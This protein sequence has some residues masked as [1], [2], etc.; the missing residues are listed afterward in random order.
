VPIGAC[1]PGYVITRKCLHA[2]KS[3]WEVVDHSS[4]QR[5]S[6]ASLGFGVA[7]LAV[8]NGR[9]D[10]I[11]VVNLLRQWESRRQSCLKID[12]FSGDGVVEFQILGV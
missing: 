10:L 4:I 5:H 11:P 9:P 12:L 7:G 8:L 6:D 1:V 3:G 2:L